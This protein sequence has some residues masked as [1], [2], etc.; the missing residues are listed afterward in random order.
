MTKQSGFDQ[1]AGASH[2]Q[3]DAPAPPVDVKAG[4]N[5]HFNH[6]LHELPPGNCE[7][8]QNGAE[9]AALRLEKR[10]HFEGARYKIQLINYGNG[11]AEI[12]W[13]FVPS[14]RP[15][16]AGRGQS[17][18]RDANE[19]RAARRARSR[20]RRLILSAKADHLLTLTYRENIT[21]FE[22]SAN[23]FAKFV[24]RVKAV[25]PGWIYI[26]I[27]ENQKRGAWHWHI[28]VVGRQ[29]VTLLRDMWRHVVGEGNIDVRPP[30]HRDGNIQ[31]LLI[32]YLSK[33]LGKGFKDGTHEFNA[34]RF[35]ASHGIKVPFKII[36]LPEDQR[37]Q[38]LSFV[39]GT[40]KLHAGSVGHV[41][42]SDDTIAGWACSWK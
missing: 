22:R 26:A 2:Q 9:G 40:L 33:Y 18:S 31:L 3:P 19:N 8:S 38:V 41:W 36:P 12:G 4:G 42:Q 39:T 11:L 6:Q 29:D 28:A 20:I 14:L 15:N 23:D 25:L 37:S 21:D 34:R 17:E 1:T 7:S 35:R 16:K 32:N 5:E 27:A 10:T 13:S 24:K 30:K